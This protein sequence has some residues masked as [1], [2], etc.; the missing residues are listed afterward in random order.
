MLSLSLHS[1][2]LFSFP[3]FLSAC[4]SEGT[5]TLTLTTREWLLLNCFH[6]PILQ[7]A[8]F[9]WLSSDQCLMASLFPSVF[10]HLF[11]SLFVAWSSSLLIF[12]GLVFF[13]SI[14]VSCHFQI[15]LFFLSVI[16]L[17]SILFFTFFY[18]SSESLSFPIF[19][20][21]PSLPLYFSLPSVYICPSFTE[22]R[23]WT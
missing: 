21:S 7:P 6:L 3:P 4:F 18:L 20:L 2:L 13:T 14:F 8:T 12:L 17:V 16:F 22:G 9:L 15:L 10:L 11:F 19:C 1:V 23:R 5:S